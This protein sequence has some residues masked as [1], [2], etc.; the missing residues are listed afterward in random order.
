M[1]QCADADNPEYAALL[2]GGDP[3]RFLSPAG[4]APTIP[5]HSEREGAIV[6]LVAHH[7]NAF[8]RLAM[9][10]AQLLLDDHPDRPAMDA[11]NRALSRHA[12]ILA[13][14]RR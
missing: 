8:A 9:D 10:Q 11:L 12:S 4:T 7:E 1:C 3:A 6:R 14:L 2:N 13:E 5:T